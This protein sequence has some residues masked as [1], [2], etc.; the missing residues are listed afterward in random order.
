MKLTNLRIGVRL[1]LG[2]GTMLLASFLM[3]VASIVTHD[4]AK[5]EIADA[6]RLADEEQAVAL[7]M[8]Q[9]LMSAAIAVRNIG[10][11]DNVDGVQS[12]EA[13]AKRER[14]AYLAA[15]T[16]LEARGLVPAQEAMVAS[17]R[18]IDAGMER[19]FTEA[20]NL[21]S[22]FNTDQ[23]AKLILTKIDPASARATAGLNDFIAA[24]KRL[25]H[26]KATEV[27]DHTAR[28]ER[29]LALAGVVALIA[30][31]LAGWRLALSIVRPL[32]KATAV[33]GQVAAGDLTVRM[34][35][36]SRDETGR[37]LHSLMS[38]ATQLHAMVKQVRESTQSIATASSEIAIGNQELSTRTET[39]ASNLQ[40][41]AASLQQ[42][43][44]MVQHLA[45]AATTA[46]Q[47]ANKAATAASSGGSV[48]ERVV[49]TMNEIQASST[50]IADITGV[51]DSIAFQTNILALNAAVEAA[52]AG[53]HG[54]S[55]GIV[56]S[57]V[58]GLAQ[59]SAEAAREIKALIS[60]SVEK[61]EAGS[62]LAADAG[63]AMGAIV[64]SVQQVTVIIG[65]ISDAAQR[66][67]AGITEVNGA[68][69]HLDQMTQQ[70][71]ALVEESAAAAESMKEQ[72]QHLS[73]RVDSFKLA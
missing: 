48:V 64:S 68:V 67:S 39:T 71:A 17:L 35:S 57:E 1:A 43:T 27:N 51:I 44:D 45:A 36:V 49:N 12:A 46:N 22:Q 58:R 33:A 70:N 15:L 30:S 31:G 34:E 69:S 59:R 8:R 40:Q 25:A 42:M 38:M 23:A 63:G 11:S 61:V 54:R 47:L 14:A 21:A 6:A 20:V 56:A 9:S 7:G 72:A 37:L 28:V 73:E 66:Q 52:R 2:M 53:E 19:D 41:A 65:E 29:A 32:H 18:A 10:L 26:Q 62:R 16:Q 3:L 13:L 55:F 4:R 50:R 5:L 60:A 24:Q